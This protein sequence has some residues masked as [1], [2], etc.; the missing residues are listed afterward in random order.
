M[1]YDKVECEI[2][3]LLS[4][5][6]LNPYERKLLRKIKRKMSKSRYNYRKVYKELTETIDRLHID[7]HKILSQRR[8]QLEQSTC[9]VKRIAELTRKN[10]MLNVFLIFVTLINLL[11]VT[12][13]RLFQ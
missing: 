8:E 12:L 7:R 3:E 11:G 9:Y 4:K 10:K 5:G 2:D 6:V 1:R 13:C